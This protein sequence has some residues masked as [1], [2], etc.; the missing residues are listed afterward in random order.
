MIAIVTVA[1]SYDVLVGGRVVFD[2]F[3]DG[4]LDEDNGLSTWLVVRGWTNEVGACEI[5]F[6]GSTR[7]VTPRGVGISCW[8]YWSGH[9]AM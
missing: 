6:W 3:L 5:Y 1:E 9:L 2:G 7:R 8:F 4:L